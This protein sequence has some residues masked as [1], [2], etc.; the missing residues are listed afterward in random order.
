MSNH[1]QARWVKTFGEILDIAP[2]Q[3]P[4]F[5]LE[6]SKAMLAAISRWYGWRTTY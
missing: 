5:S 2:K 1:I 6:N 4:E 3:G